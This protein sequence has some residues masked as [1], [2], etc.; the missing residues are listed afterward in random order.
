M[1][2]ANMSL[3]LGFVGVKRR[4][5]ISVRSRAHPKGIASESP[6]VNEEEAQ[7]APFTLR[8]ASARHPGLIL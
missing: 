5:V 6:R 7:L 8:E 1:L 2:T 4:F 3:R